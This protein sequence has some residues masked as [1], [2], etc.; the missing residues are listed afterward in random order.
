MSYSDQPDS[1]SELGQLLLWLF[2]V[3]LL[4]LLLTGSDGA[5]GD[6]SAV[7][8]ASLVAMGCGVLVL[9]MIYGASAYA[10]TDRT[11][12]AAVFGS[13]VR[14]MMLALAASVVCQAGIFVVGLFLAES[15]LIGRVH[16]GILLAVSLGAVAASFTLVSASM[17]FLRAGSMTLRGALVSPEDEPALWQTVRETAVKLGSIVPDNVVLGLEPN[18]FVTNVDVNILGKGGEISGNTLYLSTTLMRILTVKELTAIIGHELGHFR[19]EDVHFS[20]KFAPTYSRLGQALHGLE[21]NEDEG[22]GALA[23]LPALAAISTSLSRFAVA[24]RSI[25]RDRE[26]AADAAGVEVASPADLANALFKVC[27]MSE[28][29]SVLTRWNISELEQGR[30]YDRL[31]DTFSAICRTQSTEMDW[32][33]TKDDLLATQQPHPIDTHPPLAQRIAA[34]G[35]SSHE[36]EI[37]SETVPAN[38]AAE[39]LSD[40]GTLDEDLSYLEAKWLEAIGA[41]RPM[42]EEQPEGDQAAP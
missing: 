22:A 29:W 36:L 14:I 6:F 32:A 2:P 33:T 25:S 18:F 9:V 26:F 16:V 7:Y 23:K 8:W 1:A 10:G 38:S 3:P 37:G 42:I 40:A 28:F 30:F 15:S 20:T 31:S 11:R 39:L 24:E 5:S 13:S 17:R 21:T 41:F 12:L 35:V 34:L 19:G 4:G 27:A